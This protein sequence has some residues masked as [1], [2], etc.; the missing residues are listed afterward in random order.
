MAPYQWDYFLL[1]S[2]RLLLPVGPF[3]ACQQVKDSSERIMN[4]ICFSHHKYS[5]VK[6]PQRGRGGGG[7]GGGRGPE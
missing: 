1:G 3:G 5:P 4:F 6:Q 7:G 2:W